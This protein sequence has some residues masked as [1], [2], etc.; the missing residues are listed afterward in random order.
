[1]HRKKE[2]VRLQEDIR[3]MI[4]F[5]HVYRVV[6]SLS[7]EV[8]ITIKYLETHNFFYLDVII[9]ITMYIKKTQCKKYHQGIKE[10]T[11]YS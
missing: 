7:R 6:G 9:A 2:C 3:E 8:R 11:M 5:N 1:M 10:C 4:T